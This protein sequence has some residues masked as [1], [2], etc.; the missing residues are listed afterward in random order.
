M[1]WW[2]LVGRWRWSGSEGVRVA[3][4]GAVVELSGTG[5][6]EYVGFVWRS[7]S[8]FE[9]FTNEVPEM[10][11]VEEL[12]IRSSASSGGGARV[13]SAGGTS[14]SLS[15]RSMSSSSSSSSSSS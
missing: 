13:V 14:V 2:A 10:A 9:E 3:S 5:E 15:L 11:D 8:S 7:S 6:T 12:L 1:R 4:E